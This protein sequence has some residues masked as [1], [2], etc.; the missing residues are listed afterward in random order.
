MPFGYRYG[1]E[2]VPGGDAGRREVVG[3]AGWGQ[4][5]PAV[6]SGASGASGASATFYVSDVGMTNLP[7]GTSEYGFA[8]SHGGGG[9][10][11]VQVKNLPTDPAAL[12]TL[13]QAISPCYDMNGVCTR[14]GPDGQTRTK[15]LEF[16][17]VKYHWEELE[18][19]AEILNRFA[20][21]AGNT[22]GIT[23]ARV[24]DNR[25]RATFELI[26]VNGMEPAPRPGGLAAPSAI[27]TTIQV[28]ARG[29]LQGVA[30][31]LPVLLPLLGIPVDA[32]GMVRVPVDLVNV[33]SHTTATA[34]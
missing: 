18:R 4:V 1:V 30:D 33:V 28:Y 27:R 2:F 3:W 34:G 32:V 12:H 29:D 25:Y 31:A 20:L 15:R 5:W 21:S 11:Y 26:Y 6:V 19:W 10:N 17:S 7:D 13:R 22:I 16:I 14:T 9:V 8:G 24:S 23:G